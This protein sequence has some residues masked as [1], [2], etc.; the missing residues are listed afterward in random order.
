MSSLA[1]HDQV[2][3]DEVDLALQLD[4]NLQCRR[5]AVSF[6][7]AITHLNQA[8][9]HVAANGGIVFHQQQ[10]LACRARQTI[11]K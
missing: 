5:A 9:A 10:R 4:A 8:L 7:D 11:T 1:G 2:G 6:E 3:E